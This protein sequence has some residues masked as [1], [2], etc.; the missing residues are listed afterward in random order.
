M[1]TDQIARLLKP[2]LRA[3]LSAHQLEV[4]S[5]YLDLLLRWNE[6]INLTAVRRPEEIVTRHF[7][8]SFFLAQ[9]LFRPDW[10]GHVV[11]IGSGAGFPGVPIAIYAPA[12]RVTLIESNHKKATFLR[13]LTRALK[14]PNVT[15]YAGRAKE[16][17]REASPP[18]VL[19]LR[20]VEKFH[21]AVP[22]AA[23]IVR[24]EAPLLPTTNRRLAL[25]IGA[26]QAEDAKKL[27]PGFSWESPI[28]TPGST[29]R[30][31]LVGNLVG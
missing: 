11:D 10:G 3:P 31:V 16:F 12:A 25:L 7:G 6:R 30:I 4:V 22:V 17:A 14:T 9:H 13:E 23:S 1:Q 26:A 8:E 29:N 21:A 19:T 27:A 24:G 18:D 28:T 2:F 15:V 5:A 20:A